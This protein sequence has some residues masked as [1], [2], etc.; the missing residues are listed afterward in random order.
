MEMARF[1]LFVW[2][3]L[4]LSPAALLRISPAELRMTSVTGQG[5]SMISR[6]QLERVAGEIRHASAP[7]WWSEEGEGLKFACSGCGRCCQNDGDV[8]LDTDEFADLCE[9]LKMT[10]ADVLERYTD[11][12]VGGWVKLKN[13]AGKP[14]KEGKESDRCVFL[15]DD[16]KRCTIYEVRPVQCRTYPYWPK[17]LFNRTSYDAQAVQPDDAPTGPYWSSATGGCEGINHANATAPVP[18]TTIYRNSALYDTYT[19]AFPFMGSSPG[20]GDRQRLLSRIGL[21]SGV[22]R[23][24]R[25]WVQDFVLKYNLCPFAGEVFSTNRIRYRVYLG[26]GEGADSIDKLI[27]RVRFEMLALLT[28]KEDEVATTLLMLPFAF[29]NFKDWYDFSEALE[30]AVMPL[31]EKEMQ[32]PSATTGRKRLAQKLGVSALDKNDASASHIPLPEVQLAFFHP[33]FTWSESEEFNDPINFEKRA[34][35]PTINLLRAA[36]VRA[37]ASEAKTR[38]IASSN[39]DVLGSVGSEELSSQFESIIRIAL[40][41]E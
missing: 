6:R 3:I 1:S 28:A 11:E 26:G 34:P 39:V 7:K 41:E 40:K 33:S 23:S 10:P 35:F 22:S 17:L 18:S 27:D 31:L 9:G 30:D 32:G 14:S 4:C 24:T 25:A 37:W 12:I 29:S 16:G 21:I 19:G 36:R 13:K 15:D 5:Q 2:S 8:W 20:D 38:T